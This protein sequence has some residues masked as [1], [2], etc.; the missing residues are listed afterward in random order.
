MDDICEH[1]NPEDLERGD[2]IDVDAG[3]ASY[4]WT[5]WCPDCQ[6]KIEAR[7]AHDGDWMTPWEVVG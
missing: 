1:A 6:V 5:A 4:S 7:G 2:L 3:T